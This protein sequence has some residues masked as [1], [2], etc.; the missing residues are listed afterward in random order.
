MQQKILNAT[1]KYLN[2]KGKK[3]KTYFDRLTANLSDKK[4]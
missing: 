4:T 2:V 3:K 1:N